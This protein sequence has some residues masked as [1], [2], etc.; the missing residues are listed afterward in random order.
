MHVI[1]KLTNNYTYSLRRIRRT[2]SQL[3]SQQRIPTQHDMLPQHHLYRN[4]L[5][6]ECYN[7]TSARR[8]I[9]PWWWSK[10]ISKHVGVIL[11]VFL[12]VFMWN[13]CKCNCWLIIEVILRNARCNNKVYSTRMCFLAWTLTLREKQRLRMFE[14][15]VPRKVFGPTRDEETGE[16]KRLLNE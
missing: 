14:S 2:P 9:A 12:S 6:C 15:I 13:L 5:N 7:I 10:K 4:E 8:N 11:I 3:H 16:C 1:S